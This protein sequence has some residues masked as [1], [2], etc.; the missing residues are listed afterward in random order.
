MYIY[1]YIYDYHFTSNDLSLV[2]MFA[3][4]SW[5]F[6]SILSSLVVW[7]DS[8]RPP[9]Y[10]S[11]NPLRKFLETS[12][13]HHQTLVSLSL[14]CSI[15]FFYFSGKFNV[16]V[17]LFFFFLFFYFH[18]LVRQNCK[19]LYS[20]G[21]FFF[22]LIIIR[23]CLLAGIMWTVSI[24]KS[25]RISCVTFSST[26]KYKFLAQFHMDHIYDPV[27]QNLVILFW[28]FANLVIRHFISVSTYLTLAILLREIDFFFSIISSYGVLLSCY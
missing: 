28:W 12:P 1:I 11:S 18:F 24:L 7:M 14:S 10:N 27:E 20:A 5:T 21:F 9:I 15:A 13:V 16:L 6:P 17:S 22:Y 2:S 8:A 23:L 25:L 19:I 4:L 3:E 26:V